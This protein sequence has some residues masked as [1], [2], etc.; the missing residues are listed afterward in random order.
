S[1]GLD[2]KFS[3]VPLLAST[4]HPQVR[5]A[6]RTEDLSGKN[7]GKA[8]IEAIYIQLKLHAEQDVKYQKVI[9]EQD[10]DIILSITQP[11]S[12]DGKD[13]VLPSAPGKK[14]MSRNHRH[15]LPKRPRGSRSSSV[16]HRKQRRE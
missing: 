16:G 5:D 4:A 13:N 11:G 14:V 10:E 6:L 9:V 12:G 8:M 3:G 7:L 15:C 1:D 2:D